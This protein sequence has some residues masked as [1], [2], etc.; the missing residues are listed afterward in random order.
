MN[1]GRIISGFFLGC[2]G[3][4]CAF[5]FA[6]NRQAANPEDAPQ[7]IRVSGF[8]CKN[9]YGADL[10]QVYEYQGT[11]ADG[12]PYYRG[13]TRTD[14]FFYFDSRCADDTP[15]PSWLLGGQPDLTRTSD[16]NPH[17]G[18]GCENDFH[19]GDDWPVP[20]M[21]ARRTTWLWCGDRGSHWRKITLTAE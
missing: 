15:Y 11:T 20:K 9:G 3:T 19:F 18:E 21:G 6:N 5:T 16:L 10:N 14:R 17:D 4:G 2:L 12:R 13:K 1:M 8:S 7:Q